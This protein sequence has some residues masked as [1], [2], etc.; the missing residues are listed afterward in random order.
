[1]SFHESFWVVAGTAA[2][3]IALAAVISLGD[4]I[5]TQIKVDSATF[6]A[7]VVASRGD[8][9][10][11]DFQHFNERARG[12]IVA[13]RMTQLLNLYLQAGLLAVS[14][15]SLAFQRNLIPTWICVAALTAGVLVLAYA[16]VAVVREQELTRR[17]QQLI[18]SNPALVKRVFEEPAKLDR[19]TA[20]TTDTHSDPDP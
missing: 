18:E 11:K 19:D 10:A 12:S 1:M 16:G 6:D 3:V 8:K 20:S 4:T 15:L 13:L 2:P 17:Q 9:M 7:L 5:R 14:L